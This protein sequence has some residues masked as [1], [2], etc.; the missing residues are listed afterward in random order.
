[1]LFALDAFHNKSTRFIDTAPI[2]DRDALGFL[3]IFV[4]VKEVRIIWIVCPDV[5][6][7]V[8]QKDGGLTNDL[9]AL[10][11]DLSLR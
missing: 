7:V 1:M 9:G 6:S 2:H 8:V 4:V 10:F 11:L 3:K 5:A